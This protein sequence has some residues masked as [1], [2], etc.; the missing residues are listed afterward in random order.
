[1]LFLGRPSK[2][3]VSEK[4]IEQVDEKVQTKKP[5]KSPRMKDCKFQD[6]DV[7]SMQRK[8]ASSSNISNKKTNISKEKPGL[9]EGMDCQV[10]SQVP[11]TS[12]AF[13]LDSFASFNETE[14]IDAPIH[15]DNVECK[16]RK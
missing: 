10:E 15:Y 4:S 14:I 9:L 2:T 16:T 1:M 3:V 8:D 13:L 12:S 11:S 6:E 7:A 5:L